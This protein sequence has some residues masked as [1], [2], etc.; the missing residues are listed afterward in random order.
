MGY[1]SAF[2]G[3]G[4]IVMTTAA[5]SYSCDPEWLAYWY[6]LVLGAM[7]DEKADCADFLAEDRSDSDGARIGL[8]LAATHSGLSMQNLCCRF[9]AT[10]EYTHRTISCIAARAREPDFAQE[11]RAWGDLYLALLAGA[12]DLH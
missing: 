2:Y 8:Y 11:L 10:P 6:A 3:T 1:R 12:P 5:S 7:W 4:D 9:G